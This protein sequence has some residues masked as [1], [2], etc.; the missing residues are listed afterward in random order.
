MV[1]VKKICLLWVFAIFALQSGLVSAEL[2]DKKVLTLGAAKKIAA[3][4]ELEA[5]KNSWNVVIAVVDDGGH[6]LYFQRMDGAPR[7]S[8]A[9]AIGKATT[10]ANFGAPTKVFDDMTRE[11][12]AIASIPNAV[13]LEGGVPVI[14]N[15]QVVG[16]VGVSGVASH[17][18]AQTAQ[19]GIDALDAVK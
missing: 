5:E 2:A 6:L 1:S 19:A 7:G 4:A 8:V 11:R 12:P 10:S 9:V 3:A 14:V 13:F 17:Q 15:G 16:A 18:D